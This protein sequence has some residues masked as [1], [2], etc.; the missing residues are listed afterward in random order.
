MFKAA[1][2]YSLQEGG[3]IVEVR[4]KTIWYHLPNELKH[5]RYDL[6]IEQQQS[7]TDKNAVSR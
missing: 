4:H 6:Q 1:S 7:R 2:R 3:A 5:F